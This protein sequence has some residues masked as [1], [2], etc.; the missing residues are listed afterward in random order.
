MSLRTR[1]GG[2]CYAHNTPGRF[3]CST[4]FACLRRGLVADLAR[5]LLQRFCL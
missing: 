2:R 1:L 4:P 3:A 5:W